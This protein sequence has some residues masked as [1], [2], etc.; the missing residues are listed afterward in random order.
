[1]KDELHYQSSIKNYQIVLI[2]ATR[3]VLSGHIVDDPGVRIRFSNLQQAYQFLIIWF[4]E[5]NILI[6]NQHPKLLN[7]LSKK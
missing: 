6:L 3:N 2:P 7:N 4:Q 1:M 5:L